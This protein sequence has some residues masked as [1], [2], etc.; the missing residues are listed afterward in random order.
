MPIQHFRFSFQNSDEELKEILIAFLSEAGFEGFQIEEKILDAY[1]LESKLETGQ[2]DEIISGPV[3]SSLGINYTSQPLA[4]K[5]WNEEWE[6]SY[7]QVIVEGICTI[8]APFHDKTTD[9][10][11]IIIEPK[12]SF[13]TGHHS[14]TRLMIRQ[15]DRLNLKGKTIL[16]MGCGTGVLGIF[17]L[18]K[19]GKY[20]TAIDIDPWSCE[21]SFENYEKNDINP[22]RF[23]ILQGDAS[24][25]PH[26]SFD[27]I[28]ANINRNILLSDMTE[29]SNVLT[30]DGYLL[31]SGILENDFYEIDKKAK[32]LSLDYQMKMQEGS[33]ISILYK[34]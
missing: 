23:T 3:F 12:M 6:K 25:I 18:Q 30:L 15:I 28:F 29:Y 11:S 13:G 24:K 9:L 14:T 19:G 20:V 4:D 26:V 10:P 31:I 17:A 5:N 1:I 27:L 16:D 33:W 2:L 7:D 8:L 22:S 32:D 21:N 34:K